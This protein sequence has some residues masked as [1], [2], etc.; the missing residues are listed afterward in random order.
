MKGIYGISL[1]RNPQHS[2]ACTEALNKCLYPKP[3]VQSAALPNKYIN[4]VQLWLRGKWYVGVILGSHVLCKNHSWEFKPT[5]FSPL[6]WQELCKMTSLPITIWSLVFQ[7]RL[8]SLAL[9]PK[10]GSTLSSKLLLRAHLC[11]NWRRASYGL[12]SR[13]NP[14]LIRA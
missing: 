2:L 4:E 14:D 5:C 1:L 10:E 13:N 11:A 8:T 7:Q 9:L 3:W 12:P 6:R